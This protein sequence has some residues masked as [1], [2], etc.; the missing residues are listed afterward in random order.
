MITDRRPARDK[1]RLE[2]DSSHHLEKIRAPA[3]ANLAPLLGALEA[4]RDA[5]VGRLVPGR[6]RQYL[7]LAS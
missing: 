6:P 4:A 3:S 7:D 1:L 2:Y 5:A